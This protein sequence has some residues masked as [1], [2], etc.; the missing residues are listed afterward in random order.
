[1]FKPFK[2]FPI[3]RK[4]WV[5]WILPGFRVVV[6]SLQ[7]GWKVALKS[8]KRAIVRPICLEKV[9]TLHSIYQTLKYVVVSVIHLILYR[10]KHQKFLIKQTPE[11]KRK[12][13]SM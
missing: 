13:G 12:W 2:L 4:Y 5:F 8:N 6:P 3:G 10:T 1:M 7:S 11:R 9:N